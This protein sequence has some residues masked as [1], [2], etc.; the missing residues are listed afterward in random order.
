[1][2]ARGGGGLPLQNVLLRRQLGRD[3]SVIIAKELYCRGGEGDL[4]RDLEEN[5]AAN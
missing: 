3:R 5:Q 1:M 2:A 4:K